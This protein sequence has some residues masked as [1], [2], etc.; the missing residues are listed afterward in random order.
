[1][2]PEQNDSSLVPFGNALARLSEAL[3][4]PKT[5]WT[6]DAAIQ[7]FEFTIELAW[8]TIIRFARREGF[9][10]DSSRQ[11]LRAAFKLGRSNQNK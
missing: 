11:A 4:Q 10:C 7:R 5:E 2:M 9:E 8:K 6:R 1:M 3:N